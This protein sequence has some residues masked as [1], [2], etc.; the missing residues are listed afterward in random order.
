MKRFIEGEDRGQATLLPEL[1][2]DYVAQDNL[3]RVVDVFVN[4]LDLALLSFTRV[5]PAKTG[6]PAYHP[7]VLLKLYIY[8]Y[9]NRI[10]SSLWLEREAQ[11]NVELMWL[12]QRLAPD[13]KTIA[14]F[15]NDIGKA[16][17]NVCRQFV[18]LCQQLDQFFCAV[19]A[20]DGGKFKTVGSSERNFT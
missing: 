6:Q 3:V 5:Q 12:T 11:R 4:E 16:V 2:D 20:I 1:L 15:R 13:A 10:Q 18:V 7:A 17:R 9:F 8:G 19:V 14:K